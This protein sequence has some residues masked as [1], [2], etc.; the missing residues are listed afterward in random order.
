MCLGVCLCP[1][2]PEF[3]PL[4]L[5]RHLRDSAWS[6]C[7][8]SFLLTRWLDSVL[9]LF[10]S[11]LLNTSQINFRRSGVFRA[12]GTL[13]VAHSEYSFPWFNLQQNIF[14]IRSYPTTSKVLSSVAT[15]SAAR[16][17][18]TG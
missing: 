10:D 2:C 17:C 8:V 5:A 11:L 9:E 15:S 13:A 16:K 4:P 7:D 12:H 3:G 18:L 6:L 1:P 14:F